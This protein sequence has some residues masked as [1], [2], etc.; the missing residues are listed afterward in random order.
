MRRCDCIVFAFVFLLAGCGKTP[1]DNILRQISDAGHKDAE[2]QIDGLKNAAIFS[3]SSE[4]RDEEEKR[5]KK[6]AELAAS[7]EF[8]LK[9][10]LGKKIDGVSCEY[11]GDKGDAPME[12]NCYPNIGGKT[13]VGSG[14]TIHLAIGSENQHLLGTLYP[15]DTV[16]V[17]GT[18]SNIRFAMDKWTAGNLIP[19]NGDLGSSVGN[20]EVTLTDGWVQ[21]KGMQDPP[22]QGAQQFSSQQESVSQQAST[23]TVVV[24]PSAEKLVGTGSS[25]EPNSIAPDLESNAAQE[26]PLDTLTIPNQDS[27]SGINISIQSESMQARSSNPDLGVNAGS[28]A[29][30]EA[31]EDLNSKAYQRVSARRVLGKVLGV[32]MQSIPAKYEKSL[33]YLNGKGAWIEAVQAKSAADR[34]GLK[35][36]DIIIKFDGHEIESPEGVKLYLKTANETSNVEVI[37]DG[38]PK[39]L[40]V[41]FKEP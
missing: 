8:V 2:Y 4:S 6:V 10:S 41:D 20:N 35:D 3:R 9:A 12:F 13:W 31:S 24:I 34:A 39:T 25:K 30:I 36:E 29:S 22:A 11:W 40:V 28:N 21:G 14:I 32:S 23:E 19:V 18:I 26:K 37:R 38:V 1:S 16:K 15:Q 33:A 5:L 7:K 17:Y 27:T